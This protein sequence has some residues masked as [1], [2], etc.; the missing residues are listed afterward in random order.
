MCTTSVTCAICRAAQAFVHDKI[1]ANKLLHMDSQE[2][3]HNYYKLTPGKLGCEVRGIDLKRD[4]PAKGK[5]I[6]L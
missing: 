2:S 3:Q 6:V 1:L 5:I 4:V